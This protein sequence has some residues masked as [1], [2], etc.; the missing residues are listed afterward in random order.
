MYKL[1]IYDNSGNF[2]AHV[3]N[4]VPLDDK[5]MVLTFADYLSSYGELRFRI[6]TKDPLLSSGNIF[7]P[8]KYHVKLW[9]DNAVVWAGVIVNN[10]RRN[11]R[12]IEVEVFTYSFLL[13]KVQVA[14]TEHTPNWREITSGTM[15][16]AIT[17]L[18]NEGKNRSSSP[19]SSFTLGTIVNPKYPWDKE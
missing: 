4:L 3:K 6:Q 14:H 10:P 16:E 15:A 5:R 13:N 2:V 17:N 9:R 12:F 18:F 11:H 7:E 19:I 8:Y 1:Y